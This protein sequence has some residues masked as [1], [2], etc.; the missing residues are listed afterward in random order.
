MLISCL[1][2]AGTRKIYGFVDKIVFS[3]KTHRSTVFGRVDQISAG[4]RG[5]L[6]V[7]FSSGL[8]ANDP[9]FVAFWTTRGVVCVGTGSFVLLGVISDLLSHP[10]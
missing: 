7:L 6:D 3:R 8:E 9:H 2:L 5:E 10:G 1:I 4:P